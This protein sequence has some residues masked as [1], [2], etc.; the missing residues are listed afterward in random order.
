MV[1]KVTLPAGMSS[2]SVSGLHQWDYGQVLEIESP[3]LP[4]IIEVH[5]SCQG[6]TEATVRSCSVVD[7]VASVTIPDE[8]LEQS[9]PITAW[10]YE[11]EG[12]QGRTTKTI[13][14][15]VISRIRP[16]RSET[17]PVEIADAYTELITKVNELIE[18][19]AGGGVTVGHAETAT[20]ANYAASAGV[21]HTATNAATANY[22]TTAEKAHTLTQTLPPEKGGTGY[23]SL[24]ELSAALGVGQG[25]GGSLDYA[26]NAGH[27]STADS[28]GYA[29]SAGALDTPFGY[30]YDYSYIDDL[31]TAIGD[32][33][34][35]KNAEV[36]MALHN[37]YGTNYDYSYINDLFQAVD[38]LTARV[39]FLEKQITSNNGGTLM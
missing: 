39:V 34:S 31:F 12:T 4:S 20:N 2:A 19:I 30:R 21:A 13:T 11:I 37:P 9:Q 5:F 14:L 15:P 7:G 17:I 10:V 25:G 22:A 3:D 24:V 26:T 32:T 29:T 33:G 8:C 38:D 36:A 1:I 35:V 18:S 27:A 23:T 16:R 28:A 6:M